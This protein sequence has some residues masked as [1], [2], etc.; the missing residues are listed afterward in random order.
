MSKIYTDHRSR[1]ITITIEDDWP[2]LVVA[3]HNGVKIGHLEFDDYQ[4]SGIPILCHAEIK[5]EYQKAGIASEM[6]KELIELNNKIL[7]PNFSWV[8]GTHEY[9]YSQEGAA[10]INS[11]LRE[12]IITSNNIA[13]Y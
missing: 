6:F 5:A 11:C 10:L 13:H 2:P 8:S 4:D 3:K 12:K 9:Y 7:V 1:E